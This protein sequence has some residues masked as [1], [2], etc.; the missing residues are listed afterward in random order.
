MRALVWLT[1]VVCLGASTASGQGIC[2]ELAGPPSSAQGIPGDGQPARTE[3]VF[4]VCFDGAAWRVQPPPNGRLTSHD[5]VWIRV[6]HFNFLRYTLSMDVT[7]E[8][9]ESYA[10]LTKLW[11]SVLN[12]AVAEVFG[13]LG[14]PPAAAPDPL[15]DAA[16]LVYANA[17]RLQRQVQAALA[18]YTRPG[19]TAREAETLA[20]A[21]SGVR[22]AAMRLRASYSSL[23]QLVEG[24][25]EAFKQAF[26]GS[27]KAYYKLAVDSYDEAI[28]RSD[29][30]LRLADRTLS[31]EIRRLGT[32][33]A[34]TR[35]TVT[36]AAT[37]PDGVRQEVET[38]HYVSQSSMPLVAHGGV[39]FSGIRDVTFEKV[40][41]A[42]EFSE[43]DFFARQASD[44]T[45]TG[46]STFLAWQ[47]FA[48]ARSLD[49]DTKQQPFGLLLSIGTDLS[50]PGHRLY[51]GPSLML[52]SRLVLTTGA[53]FGRAS[54]GEDP[55]EPDVF[56]LV[57][58]H[59]E[60]SW[61]TALTVR[62]Y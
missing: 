18:P 37:D 32:R 52:F 16:R 45:A 27:M 40:R 55:I 24:D 6:R 43:E 44:T 34:G 56:R 13:A 11:S 49:A 51:L 14:E 4:D 58:E 60:T 22:D 50:S 3:S 47:V 35:V 7:E 38:I 8:R 33:D 54:D 48:V 41:R 12:P 10:Y 46:F 29:S 42:V 28:G 31:D 25:A 21:T 19:L 2:A 9:A 62:L 1:C 23:Q 17:Q 59:G 57:R 36:L 5:D 26:G 53:A 20:T 15:L 39:A 61:F 30:F